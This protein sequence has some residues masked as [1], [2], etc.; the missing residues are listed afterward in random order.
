[1]AMRASERAKLEPYA[2]VLDVL[3]FPQLDQVIPMPA[4]I[5]E[6]L[7]IESPADIILRIRENI[8][9]G[10]RTGFKNAVKM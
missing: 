5:I 6:E 1:M 9:A 10:M 8:R 4:E 7:G 2:Y 3:G